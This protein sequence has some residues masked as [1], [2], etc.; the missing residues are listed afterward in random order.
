M[1]FGARIKSEPA[2]RAPGAETAQV[3]PDLGTLEAQL[4]GVYGLRF[5]HVSAASCGAGGLLLWFLQLFL[6]G[7]AVGVLLLLLEFRVPGLESPQNL[8]LDAF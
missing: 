2:P 6:W 1:L 3:E 5:S 4:Y 8:G 7:V